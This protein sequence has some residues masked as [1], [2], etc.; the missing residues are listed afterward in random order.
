MLVMLLTVEL[1]SLHSQSWTMLCQ[2][3][4]LVLAQAFVVFAIPARR[5]RGST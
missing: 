1:H 2:G 4:L 5:D 3:S